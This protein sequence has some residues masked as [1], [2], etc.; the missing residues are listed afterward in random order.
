MPTDVAS[1]FVQQEE[2]M[3]E[4]NHQGEISKS[5]AI[6]LIQSVEVSD[7]LLTIENEVSIVLDEEKVHQEIKTL[8]VH[9]V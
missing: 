6:D 7:I 1:T 3:V 8:R 2:P 4:P 5:C 9:I